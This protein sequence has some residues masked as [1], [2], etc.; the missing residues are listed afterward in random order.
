MSSPARSSR[1]R[2]AVARAWTGLR[3]FVR[4]W[5]K[6]ALERAEGEARRAER[7]LR[8]A[9]DA[10]PEGI[11][12]LDRQ[13]RYILWNQRYAEIYRTS[14][15]LF[16]VGAR[17]E[18]TLRVG[19]ARGDY[20]DAIGREEAWLEQ[21][22]SLMANPGVRHEQRL[23]DGRWIMIE[24]RKTADQGTIGIRVDITDM[25]RQ[26]EALRMALSQA[27][28]AHRAK[29]DFL[30]NM[31]H[32]IRTPLNGVLGLA[33]VLAESPLSAPQ[34]EMAR[35]I[36][37]SATAL[38]GLLGD[39]LVFAQMEAGRL[40]LARERLRLRAVVEEAVAP[41]RGEAERK[42]LAL[43]L[44]LGPEADK[45]L[46]GDPARLKQILSNLLSNAVKFT[47]AGEVRVRLTADGNGAARRQVL[48]VADTGIG[49]DPA[50]TE[51]LFLGFEQADSSLTRRFG[52][53]GLGLAICRQLAELMG[54]AIRAEGRPGRGATFS[55]DL[56]LPP[57]PPEV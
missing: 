29:S 18:D 44:D 33:G 5:D 52:G 42:G 48:E 6:D 26:A 12:F 11:V 10:L 28:A 41:F 9:I 55:L 51:R 46:L 24:E 16:A 54:G 27:Q 23:A 30:A 35:A 19:I 34:R 15:D 56:S 14:A 47:A 43:V 45:P 8:D 2:A 4:R 53:A 38:D 39:L 32:E 50:E 3:A 20:P 57:A 49:F 1:S 37:A 17:L 13:G 31:S 7:R 40:E 21:R 36:I 22:L 25:K